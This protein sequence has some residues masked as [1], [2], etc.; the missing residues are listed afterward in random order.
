MR[1]IDKR[2]ISWNFRAIRRLKDSTKLYVFPRKK[3]EVQKKANVEF[4]EQFY[5]QTRSIM[6]S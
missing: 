1:F 6:L 5:M 4:N 2:G 3:E